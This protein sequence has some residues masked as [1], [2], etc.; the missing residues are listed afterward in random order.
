MN[1]Y[2][3][4]FARSGRVSPSN[5]EN[6]SVRWTADIEVMAAFPY[7]VT[8]K[9]FAI[10]SDGK[11]ILLGGT[12]RRSEQGE[13]WYSQP[14]LWTLDL[15]SGQL[16]GFH[17]LEVE[18]GNELHAAEGNLYLSY[19]QGGKSTFSCID[20]STKE[21]RWKSRVSISEAPVV[22]GDVIYG[23]GKGRNLHALERLTGRTIWRFEALSRLEG[24]PSFWDSTIFVCGKNV[25]YAV[26]A[27]SGEPRFQVGEP[28]ETA[29]FLCGPPA[30]GRGLV[31]FKETVGGRP[32]ISAVRAV[33]GSRLWHFGADG[34]LTTSA[35]DDER[36]Y[37]GCAD[38]SLYALDWDTG[39]IVWTF[40]TRSELR[41][42]PLLFG[43]IV[44]IGDCY[45]DALLYGIDARTGRKVWEVELDN[46]LE[47]PLR[48]WQQTVFARTYRRLY[49]VR[50][51]Q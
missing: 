14:T 8:Y 10:T 28:G 47:A 23:C 19:R 25:L 34:I 33:D 17:D 48:T 13:P 24:C 41:R 16:I 9:G 30:V 20:A 26:D 42:G 7:A 11:H 31:V 32:G 12:H 38:R 43:A 29:E 15:E 49:V 21:L 35:I 40:K 51:V 6:P 2:G 3:G 1:P 22:L 39:A 18:P 44:V 5:L 50:T 27:S 36:V 37:I 45:S 4:D 46:G